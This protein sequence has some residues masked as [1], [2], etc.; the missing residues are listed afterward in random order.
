[1][2]DPLGRPAPLCLGNRVFEWGCKTYLMGILNVTPDS[3]SGDGLA[4][5]IEKAVAKAEQMV[6][7]GADIIDVGAESTRP[8]ATPVPATEEL[9]RVIPVIEELAR[10][11]DVPL[12][13]DTYK[14][15]VARSA[16]RAGARVINDVWGL[17]RDPAL[18]HVAAEFEAPL[19]LCHNSRP[20]K[21][22]PAA[23]DKP[24]VASDGDLIAEIINGLRWSIEVARDVGVPGRN[25]I[26]DP[27]IG[28][29]KKEEQN[30]MIIRRLAEI[31]CLGRPILVG[32]SRK[33][34][35]GWV[36]DLPVD[37]RLEGTAAT[38]AISVAHGADIVRVHDVKQM[39]RVVRMVDAI[40]RA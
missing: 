3:F 38:V 36:L 2:I 21:R 20:L 35:I 30:L 24:S 29:G 31:R 40:V 6:A 10:V 32:P 15:E 8:G 26:V 7:D 19:I 22:R 12:S 37:E 9:R 28:F 16:L 25:I 23:R 34:F 33:G 18:A 1:M 17:R 11:V 4:D 5:D 39:S 14:A 27:G 13:I